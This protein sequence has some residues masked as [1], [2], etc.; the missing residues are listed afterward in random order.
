MEAPVG[1]IAI[2]CGAARA[3]VEGRHRRIAAIVG[4]RPDQRIARTALRAIDEGIAEAAILRIGEFGRAVRAQ[5]LV[6]RNVHGR[7]LIGAAFENGETFERRGGH[8][9]RVLHDRP[10]ERRRLAVQR[11]FETVES[12]GRALGENLDLAR[13]I[14]HPAGKIMPLREPKDEGPEADALD[15]A[16]ETPGPRLHAAQV[17]SLSVTVSLA[18]RIWSLWTIRQ[19]HIRPIC[20][21]LRGRK[22]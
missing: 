13:K 18:A 14:A 11:P 5:E 19:I 3:E 16:A 7:R 9:P 20:S 6:G 22:G 10:G 1:G 15:T 12:I 21:R 4:K 8:R 2:F 17:L